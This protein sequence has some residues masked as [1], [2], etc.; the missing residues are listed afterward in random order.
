MTV[1][2]FIIWHVKQLSIFSLVKNVSSKLT[3][4]YIVW[5]TFPPPRPARRRKRSS[6][7]T[8]NG[9]SG[10]PTTPQPPQAPHAPLP[11]RNSSNDDIDRL[12]TLSTVAAAAATVAT[13]PTTKRRKL[14][15]LRISGTVNKLKEEVEEETKKEVIIATLLGLGRV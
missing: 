10:G 3:D 7:G 15:P 4:C 11:H 12:L 9:V 6:S 5:V 13:T 1:Q 8:D 2:F 14:A